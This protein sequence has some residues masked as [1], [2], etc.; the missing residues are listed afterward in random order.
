MLIFIYMSNDSV[1]LILILKTKIFANLIVYVVLRR[2]QSDT[3][4]MQVV[5]LKIRNN[6][7]R[8]FNFGKIV[9]RVVITGMIILKVLN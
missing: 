8:M 2:S 9:R 6:R 1:L 3:W 4:V 7:L 5:K